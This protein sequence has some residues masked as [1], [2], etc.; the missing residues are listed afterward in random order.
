MSGSKTQVPTLSSIPSIDELLRTSSANNLIEL[1]GRAILT[2]ALRD[3]TGELRDAIKNGQPVN[4]ECAAIVNR[5]NRLL[6]KWLTPTLM[7]VFNLTGTVLHTNLGRATLPP[8]AIEAMARVASQPVNLE[9][10]L[11]DGRR[12]DRDDHLNNLL[13]RL[14]GAE[15]AT[16]VNNNA[17]AV[18]L[19]LNTLALR[20]R[21]LV[22]RGELIEIGGSF[23]MPDIMAR[24]GC[25]LHEVGTTNRTHLKD[26]A[27]A[28]E[29]KR[30]SRPA[31]ILQV[32]TSNYT[33]EGFTATVEPGALS[34]LAEKNDVP[35]YVD[36]GSGTLVDLSQFGLPPEPTVSQA[37]RD[38]ADLVSFSGDKMLGGP[39]AG[40]IVGRADLIDKIK[41]N[42][43][44]RAMRI[45]KMTIAAL[46]TV[47]EF[48][49]DPENLVERVP[50]LRLLARPVVE[51]KT[52]AVRLMPVIAQQLGD[53]V[54]VTVTHCSSQVGSGSLPQI[55]I[56]SVAITIRPKGGRRRA[57]NLA[58]R[59]AESFHRLRVPVIGRMA[60][61]ALVLDLRCLKNEAEFTAQLTRLS[62]NSETVPA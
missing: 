21:V 16:V 25:K 8:E 48:Y 54:S 18:L 9:Y 30:K 36:L 58:R 62:W 12:G 53:R 1:H 49:T 28:L 56:P 17:A 20:R 32:H 14:T 33:I 50:T 27:D 19:C 15:A 10:K 26:F 44:K 59:L 34:T 23:R 3:I 46:F 35:F 31:L 5:A 52:Q 11:E 57:D 40:I 55:E 2:E 41:R 38:G 4:A 43:M 61:G 51:I 39:Q 60:D 13:C 7:P 45:N 24:A 22:S 47:L 29:E 42:P 6:E 37:L